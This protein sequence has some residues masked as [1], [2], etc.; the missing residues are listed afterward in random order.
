MRQMTAP[1]LARIRRVMVVGLLLWPLYHGVQ[2][3]G[4]ATDATLQVTPQ[5][6]DFGEVKRLGGEVQTTFTVRNG[7]EAP[8]KI[9]RI[10]TS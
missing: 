7:G 10:W 6:H 4:A 8:I 5:A 2:E 1:A 3:V 9:R